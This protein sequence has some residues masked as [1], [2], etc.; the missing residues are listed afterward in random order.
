MDGE[1]VDALF[2][3]FNQSVPEYLPGQLLSPAINLLEGLING[4][5]T[6]GHR[7]VAQNPLSRLVD[8]SARGKV[9]D[10]I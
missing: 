6:D 7:A 4:Y 5:S 3:L 1:V 2:C 9:H 8:V 10:G